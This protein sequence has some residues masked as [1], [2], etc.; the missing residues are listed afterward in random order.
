[1]VPDEAAM[2]RAFAGMV[3]DYRTRCL[4]FMRTDHY[5]VTREERLRVLDYV[6]RYG[7]RAGHV[8]AANLRRW[9]LQ[10]SNAASA[11]S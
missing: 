11:V 10:P 7:D 9:L 1:M 5:P 6:Q 8:R 3:D 2:D 4:W